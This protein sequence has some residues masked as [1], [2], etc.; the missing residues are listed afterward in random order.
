MKVLQT[1]LF[2]TMASMFGMAN[3]QVQITLNVDANPNPKISEW[4]DRS[5]L[6]ILTVT[7]GEQKLEGLE[8]KIKV[9]IFADNNLVAETNTNKVSPRE[10]SIG[11]DI[12]M[13]E[14]VVPFDA[15]SMYGN[16]S[17]TVTKTGMLPAGVYSFCVS[18]VDM[19]NKIISTPEEVCRPMIITAYQMPELIFPQNN[20]ELNSALLQGTQFVWTPL[21]PNPPADM[22]VKYIVAISE[23]LPHQTPSQALLVNHPLV[24][25]EVTGMTRMTWPV[26]IDLPDDSTKYVWSVKALTMDDDAYH[27]ENA[28]FSSASAFIVKP[29]NPPALGEAGGEGGDDGTP[30]PT[31]GPLAVNDVFFAGENGEFEVAVT[32]VTTNNNNKHTGKGN[33]FVQWLNARVEVAFDTIVVDVNRVLTQGKIIAAIHDQAPEYP[34]EWALEAAAN[35]NFTNQIAGDVISWVENTTNQTIPFNNL[36]EYTTPVKIPLGVVLPNGNEFAINEMIFLPAKSEFNMIAAKTI[37]PSWGTTRLGFRAKNIRFH[38]TQIEMPPGRIE[39]VEDIAIGNSNNDMVFVFKKPDT[40]HLGC[41]IEWDEDGFSE[42]G[43]ELETL[44]TR[45]WLIPSPDD[46]PTKK[47]AASVSANGTDWDDLIL[48][49][50]LQKAE[51]V[52]SGGLTILA[53]SIYYD[54]SDVMNAPAMTFPANY[55]GDMTETFRGFFMKALEVEMPDAWQTHAGGKPKMGVY[56]MIIDNMGVT[57]KAEATSIVQ[58]PNANVADLVASIDTVHVDIIA[59]SLVEAGAKGQVG[60]PLTKKDSIQ[61]PLEYV[62]LFNNP[63]TPGQPTNFQFTVTPTGPINAHILKGEMEL[64]E[65]SNIVAYVDNTQ[66]TFDINLDGNFAWNSVKL[67]PIKE[68]DFGLDFQGLG[69]TYDSTNGTPFGF[70]IGTWGFA[71]PQKRL[72]NFPVTIDEIDFKMLTP[73]PGQL[74]KG[75]VGL[76]VVFNLTSDIG[77]MSGLGVEFAIKDNTSGQKFYPE[78]LR[79]SIDSIAVNANLAAVDIKGAVGFRNDDPVFGNGFIGTLNAEFKAIGIKV[80]ALAEFGNTAYLNNNQLY[81]YWRVEA[82]VGL[83]APGVVFMPGMAFRG[84]G[85]GAFYNMTASLSGTT[86]SFTPKKSALGFRAMATLATTPKEDGFNTDVGLLGEF[87]TSGGLTYIGFTGDFWVGANLTSASRNKAK[88]DGN[89]SASYNFPDRHFNFSTNVNVNAP[90]ITTPSAVNMVLDIDGKN[91]QWYFKFGEPQNLNTVRVFGINLYE[92]LMFGN[93]IPTPN[94][95]TPSFRNNYHGALG[96][97]PGGVGSGGVGAATKTGSGFALGIGFK[98][99][100]NDLKHLTGNYYLGYGLGAGAELHLAFMNYSGSCD[101]YNPIGIN[102]WRASGGLGFYGYAG[103]RVER[104][105][106]K[107]KDKTWHIASLAAGAW[108][109]GEFPNPYYAAGAVSGHAKIAKVINVSFHK[110]F[111]VGAQ[112][113]NAS[114]GPGAP[115]VPGD[116]AA[117]QQEKLIQYVKPGAQYNYPVEEPL[118]VKY[119]LI[120]D[121]VFDVSEQQA[122]GTV[123]NRTFKMTVERSLQVKDENGNWNTL[124][125]SNVQNNLGEYLYIKYNITEHSQSAMNFAPNT[126]LSGSNSGGTPPASNGMVFQSMTMPGMNMGIAGAG[127]N[128]GNSTGA[129]TG[130]ALSPNF[131]MQL[132]Y[133]VVSPP[134]SYGDLPPTSPPP[135]N[136]LEEDKDYKFVVTATLKE[137]KNGSWTNA[138]KRDLTPVTETIQKNFRTGEMEAVSAA[139]VMF[140]M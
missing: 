87:S 131:Q 40:N 33:V 2:I 52:G 24:E 26:D 8:Y 78:Y 139:P 43:I 67:G 73:G 51:I 6:A 133:P 9:K 46:D 50:T 115:V 70:N 16:T 95:F 103:A 112:C 37:P 39:L 20:A 140:S 126:P 114:V 123:L 107:L 119:G 17:T 41:F 13:A 55:P 10:L 61:N 128:N 89:L 86:Y 18:L 25:E 32:E 72:A 59:N 65:T 82:E 14:E 96:H 71:S 108:I 31:P 118:A 48:G 15:V 5:E 134:P 90:P 54:F 56:D 83:P 100:K 29:Q 111:E 35:L 23:V 102:G 92:Y 27:A 105:G 66:K 49:G 88:V 98:F 117:D 1:L 94:G 63:Q 53:D 93:H 104:I 21:T 62:A 45:D 22:G 135:L 124:Q 19:N 68:V 99:N 34:Q 38:P 76:D 11:S 97:Y 120:P 116:V 110:Q 132:P 106:G 44:F 3:A 77:G 121:E 91:N 113:S 7:N 85:G 36:T 4:M 42:Y 74:L 137:Y 136:D 64:E 138:L 12:F 101:G 84:F 122:D 58:F 47:V 130:Q 75:R 127:K 109:Y 80:G 57:L 69:M 30:A 60:L 79:A 81:R 129:N 28:G 125:V